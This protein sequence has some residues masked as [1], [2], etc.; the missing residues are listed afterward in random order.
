MPP[1]GNAPLMQVSPIMRTLTRF[2]NWWGREIA[3]L[4]PAWLRSWWGRG[5]PTIFLSLDDEQVRIERHSPGRNESIVEVALDR[6]NPVIQGAELLRRLAQSAGENYRLLLSLP[7]ASMLRRRLQLPLATEEN[8]GQTLAFE[9]DR[10]T[11]FKPDDVYFDF[12][13][14]R[15]DPSRNVLEVDLAVV[16]RSLVDPMKHQAGAMG[17]PLQGMAFDGEIL[18]GRKEPG[19]DHSA[20]GKFSLR[21]WSRIALALLVFLLLVAFLG[22]PL[23]QKRAAAI[24]LLQ[25]LAEARKAATETDAMRDRL[26]KLVAEHNALPDKKW[27]S[28]SLV[29]M[30][31]ELSRRL[32]D[33]TFVLTFTLEGMTITLQGESGSAAEL[34]QILEASPQFQNVVFKSPL[35]KLPGGTQDR[36]HLG[37]DISPE[38]M[39]KPDTTSPG[40]AP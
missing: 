22:I 23:W 38:E 39:H 25:P 21:L 28:P 37:A 20:T 3:E 10:Y 24:A 17:L 4:F 29:R 6:G 31:D 26:E 35:T 15:R 12:R 2:L 40:G 19:W 1:P 16:R 8:L 9:L 18:G 14:C 36:F 27:A 30:L 33:D 32:K 34:V 13:V 11:P 7:A 5:V